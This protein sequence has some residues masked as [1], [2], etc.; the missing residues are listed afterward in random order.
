MSIET[1]EVPGAGAKQQQPAASKS[2]RSKGVVLRFS[3]TAWAK[4][5]YFRDRQET[6]IGGFAVTPADDLLYVHEFVTV[7]QDVSIATISF[8]D[9]A[10]ADFFESQV[11]KG[12]KPEQFART[13][14][15]THPGESP[16]PSS[17][18]EETFRRVFGR[19]DWAVM[20][21][22]GK[23]GKTHARLRFNVGPGGEA[24]IP[25][26]VDYSLPF[27]GVDR[28]AWEAEYKANVH[29]DP[30]PFGVFSRSGTSSGRR[31]DPFF[32]LEGNTG[33]L[34]TPDQWLQTLE[35]M[36]PADRQLV[37]EELAARPDLWDDESEVIY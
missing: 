14:L 8:H 21:V 13:W 22:L 27:E 36:E 24:I 16:E 23:K 37:V 26:E 4:L 30:F 19:C 35:A 17:V 3:P 6:E 32:D 34:P 15:H 11:D 28:N 1:K 2:A 29:E 25:V 12:R 18:D 31:G 5:L 20:F 9:E 7:K 33:A 10:V